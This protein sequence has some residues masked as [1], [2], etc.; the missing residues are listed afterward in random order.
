MKVVMVYFVPPDGRVMVIG[1]A[2]EVEPVAAGSELPEA[3]T[4]WL[5]SMPA[6]GLAIAAATAA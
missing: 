4:S 1:T 6:G 3:V 5:R 2:C